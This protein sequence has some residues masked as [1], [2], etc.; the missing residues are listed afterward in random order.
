M[1]M[2]RGMSKNVWSLHVSFLKSKSMQAKNFQKMCQKY[3][4]TTTVTSSSR[5]IVREVFKEESL[6]E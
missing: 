4:F 5:I 2:F 1:G 3:L 6:E